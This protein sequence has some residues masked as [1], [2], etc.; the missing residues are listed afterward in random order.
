LV[1]TFGKLREER[2]GVE[3]VRIGVILSTVFRSLLGAENELLAVMTA[4]EDGACTQ[5]SCAD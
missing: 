3:W 4:A 2:E 1:D 5:L